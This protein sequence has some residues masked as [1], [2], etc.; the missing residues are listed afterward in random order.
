MGRLDAWRTQRPVEERIVY[1]RPR[2]ILVVL[3]IILVATAIIAFLFLAWHVITW[4]LIALFL[5]LAL[6][7]AVEFFE[8]HGLR[9]EPGVG[10]R[11]PA[12]ARS[13][14]PRSARS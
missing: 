7:P 1:F 3:G 12:R 13:P 4:I 8:R 11:L 10:A 9:R 5:A 14:S 2:A 6:N